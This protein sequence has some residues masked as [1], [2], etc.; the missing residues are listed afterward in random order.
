VSVER[1]GL[2]G[3]GRS[4]E[5]GRR[6]RR[7][8]GGAVADGLAD[9]FEVVEG[10]VKLV[11]LAGLVSETFLEAGFEFVAPAGELMLVLLE[12]GRGAGRIGDRRRS[13]G[14]SARGGGGGGHASGERSRVMGCVFRSESVEA[15]NIFLPVPRC[16]SLLLARITRRG[17]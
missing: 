12:A 15:E 2:G 6:G 10:V 7:E 1:G 9:A 11:A 13:G 8:V 16:D 4:G 5:A 3:G 17:K 14:G